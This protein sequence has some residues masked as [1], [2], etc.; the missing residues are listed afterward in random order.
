[1]QVLTIPRIRNNMEVFTVDLL[2][3]AERATDT[4]DLNAEGK[5]P[6]KSAGEEGETS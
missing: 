6:V 4:Q 2:D 5:R 3:G 1:M